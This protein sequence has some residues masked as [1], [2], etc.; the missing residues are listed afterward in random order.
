MEEEYT[1]WGKGGRGKKYLP[2]VVLIFVGM[3]ILFFTID[4]NLALR[5]LVSSIFLLPAFIIITW[6]TYRQQKK[7][8]EL[9]KAKHTTIE[10]TSNLINVTCPYCNNTFQIPQQNK[11]FKAKCPKCGKVS[12]LR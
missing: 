5:V 12:L 2:I 11:P 4:P 1:I 9:E 8:Y 10:K 3:Q 6:A 7:R